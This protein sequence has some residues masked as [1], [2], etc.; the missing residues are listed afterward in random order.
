MFC[1]CK[2]DTPNIYF[3]KRAS[4]ASEMTQQVKA[5]V[6]Q[7]EGLCLI[8]RTTRWKRVLPQIVL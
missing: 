2:C 6:A 5:L 7:C 4:G 1:I 8:C 3:M